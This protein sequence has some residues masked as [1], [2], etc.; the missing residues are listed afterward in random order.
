MKKAEKERTIEEGFSELNAILQKMDNNE[1]SL[2]ESFELYNEG[3]NIV[4]EL[5]GKLSEVEGKLTIV[6]EEQQI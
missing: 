4:K 2:E 5:N 3:L 1:V 6:N